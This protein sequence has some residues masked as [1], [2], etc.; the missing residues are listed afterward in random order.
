[1]GSIYIYIYI[2]N[3]VWFREYIQQI[4]FEYESDSE[5]TLITPI[6]KDDLSGN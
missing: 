6:L 1:M 2:Y 3:I 5:E 4:Q